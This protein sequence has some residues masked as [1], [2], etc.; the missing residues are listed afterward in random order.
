M[1]FGRRERKYRRLLIVE[2]EPLV[3]FDTEHFLSEHGYVVI[4]TVDNAD[5]A[6]DAIAGGGIDLI[7]SDF[8]LSRASNGRDV[9]LA[10]QAAGVPLL[11]VTARCPADAPAIAIGCLAKPYKQRDLGLA[12]DAVEAKLGG[13]GAPKRVPKGLSLY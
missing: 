1:L 8:T 3:A 11:F 10:A 13:E 4:A 6:R 5:D 12:L 7:L 9:A 2:D